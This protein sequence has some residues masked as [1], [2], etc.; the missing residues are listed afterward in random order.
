MDLLTV[1]S[2]RNYLI[3]YRDVIKVIDRRARIPEYLKNENKDLLHDIVGVYTDQ[4]NGKVDY[5]SLVEDLREFN[6][7]D[8]NSNKVGDLTESRVGA[9]SKT[10]GEPRKRKTIFED[11]YIVLDSQKV[12]ANVLETIETRLQKVTR[13]L[14]R[15]Y[16]SEQK[17]DE[18]L[19]SDGVERNGNLSVDELKGFVLKACKEQLIHRNINKKDIE[20]FLS[21]FKYNA[22]GATNVNNVAKMVFTN[23]NYVSKELAHKTR[24]NPPPDA[25]N[26]EMLESIRSVEI[27]DVESVPID[28][29][30]AAAVLK[31]IENKVFCGGLPRAGTYQSVYKQVF[32]ADGDGFVSHADFETACRKL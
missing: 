13:H 25:V 8:A 32:D 22:Y 7:E 9:F 2:E 26:V 4:D 3:D 16:G 28:Y 12:P 14:K 30:R 19:K 17:L 29:K 15:V 5:R 24:A 1:D 6:Y 10:P 20:A 18:A 27:E 31:E 21:A 11:N 23:D